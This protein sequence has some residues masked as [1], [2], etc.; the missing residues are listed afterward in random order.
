MQTHIHLDM[1]QIFLYCIF[2]IPPGPIKTRSL[3]EILFDLKCCVNFTKNGTGHL[4]LDLVCC[5]IFKYTS[6]VLEILS[7][8]NRFKSDIEMM[9]GKYPFAFWPYWYFTWCFLTPVCC[10]VCQLQLLLLHS[11]HRISTWTPIYLFVYVH[12]ATKIVFQ[13]NLILRVASA[14]TGPYSYAGAR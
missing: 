11:A 5:L 3:Q 7:G 2:F 12:I 1:S 8:V 14:S 10:A 13:M 6:F 9:L 4:H